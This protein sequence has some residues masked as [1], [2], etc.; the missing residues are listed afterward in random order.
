MAI[1]NGSSFVIVCSATRFVEKLNGLQRFSLVKTK[2]RG[3]P[4]LHMLS[5]YV[6]VKTMLVRCFLAVTTMFFAHEKL[7]FT[8]SPC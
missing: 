5:S 1:E 7:M 8:P 3:T 4:I 6:L 2:G